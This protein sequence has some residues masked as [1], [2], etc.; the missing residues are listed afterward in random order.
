MDRQTGKLETL[1]VD[2]IGN[3]F[4]EFERT[5]DGYLRIPTAMINGLNDQLMITPPE[6]VN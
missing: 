4:K 6:R 3:G 5:D 2:P 1:L